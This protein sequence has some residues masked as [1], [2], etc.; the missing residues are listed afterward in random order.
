MH[1]ILSLHACMSRVLLYN[2]LSLGTKCRIRASTYIQNKPDKYGA[3]IFRLSSAS[4]IIYLICTYLFLMIQEII[5]L[6]LFQN[7]LQRVILNY[8][9]FTTNI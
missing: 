9:L 7:N 2:K 6:N 1:K 4:S 3:R 5:I 8:R